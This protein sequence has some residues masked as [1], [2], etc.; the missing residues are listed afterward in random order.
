MST[1]S[2]SQRLIDKCLALHLHP[3]AVLLI[4]LANEPHRF[5]YKPFVPVCNV[6]RNVFDVC[7]TAETWK[8]KNARMLQFVY[9]I[10]LDQST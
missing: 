1:P 9:K 7:L 5:R 6:T 8:C 2:I 10:D 4:P 3:Y